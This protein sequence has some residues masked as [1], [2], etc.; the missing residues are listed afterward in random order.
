MRTKSGVKAV[1]KMN[2]KNSRKTNK[3]AAA[4][5][6]NRNESIFRTGGVLFFNLL[7]AATVIIC[8]FHT[9]ANFAAV[10]QRYECLENLNREHNSLRI[11][12]DALR[13]RLEKSRE[14]NRLLDEDYIISVARAHGLRKDSDIVFYLYSGE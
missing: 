5:P 7:I 11:K 8:L 3:T 12:N 4:K 1:N 9:V 2:N 6:E 13:N 10:A 14:A